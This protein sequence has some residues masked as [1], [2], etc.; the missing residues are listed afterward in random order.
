M[1]KTIKKR[2]TIICFI[3]VLLLAL[4]AAEL[5]YSNLAVAVSRYTMESSKTAAPFRIVF[6]SD[7]HSREF[8]KN[9]GRLLE[10]IAAEEPDIIAL[11]GDIFDENADEETIE[12]TC[13]FIGEAAKIAPVYFCMGNHE[14]DLMAKR[15][16]S[17]KE[18]IAEAG[19][20]VLDASYVDI[21]INGTPVR[22]GG[23]E[24]YYRTPHMTSSN[25]DRQAADMLFF[26]DFENTER[27]KLLLN[28]ISTNWLDWDYRD[29]CPVDLVLSGHYHGGVVR[30][31]LL[32]RGLF[33]PYVGW[34]PPYTK[35]IFVGEKAT[36]I[37]S[38]GMAGAKGY[39]R[40]FNPP[41]IVVVDV[42][43]A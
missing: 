15:D 4:A 5:L 42:C 12:K 11:V 16:R 33:A 37:L 28:H 43:P 23:Y 14:Y 39:P 41:E 25:A 27:F 3:A 31:P 7:L 8:G 26:E 18:R 29:R 21:E 35:G 32:N 34:F 36:C 9:N 20:V 17:L 10:K 19:A 1:K 13:D 38:T 22:L 6:I 30:I 2:I 40:F 24:G